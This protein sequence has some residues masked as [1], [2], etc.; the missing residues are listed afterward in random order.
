MSKSLGNFYTLRD[1]LAKGWTG[2][3][4]RYALIVAHYREP[5]QFYI[6]RVAGGAIGLQRLDELACESTSF[7]PSFNQAIWRGTFPTLE[8]L[9]KA[10]IDKR[11]R[12]LSEL[13]DGFESSL[14]DDLNISA[15]LAAWFEFVRGRTAYNLARRSHCDTCGLGAT[16]QG[17]GSDADKIGSSGRSTSPRRRASGGSQVQ[18]L[19]TLRMRFVIS[20]EAGMGN[21][22]HAERS[23]RQ[24]SRLSCRHDQTLSADQ[25]RSASISPWRRL[26][27]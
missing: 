19:Q 16:R 4:V 20:C 15:A 22:R 26:Q 11:L 21:R 12:E 24:A 25:I 13:L 9:R 10:V 1:L 23:T 5:T 3:E 7:S 8:T 6:R 14:D 27:S 18:G 17:L 2:R